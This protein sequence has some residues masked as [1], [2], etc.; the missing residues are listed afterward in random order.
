MI[1]RAFLL[2]AGAATVAAL[3]PTSASAH[4]QLSVTIGSGYGYYSPYYGQNGYDQHDQSD[5]DH[6]DNH[7]QLDEAHAQAHEE[8]ATRWEH[9]R[10][11]RQLNRQHT[12]ADRQLQ[13][14]HQEQHQFQQW[15]QQNYYG[16]GY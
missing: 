1:F 14:Q 5:A 3:I 15:R 10:L 9:G 6:R 12:Q 13:W 16:Y 2:A 8:G 11:H 7:D 4:S